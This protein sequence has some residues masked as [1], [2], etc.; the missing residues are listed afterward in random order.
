MLNEKETELVLEK[1]MKDCK[2]FWK[3][4]GYDELEASIKAIEEI[5]EMTTDMFSPQGKKLDVRTK[6]KFVESKKREIRI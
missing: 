1:A 2:G 5:Q 6:E 3:R 4:Q